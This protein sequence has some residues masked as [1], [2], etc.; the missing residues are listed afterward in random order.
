MQAKILAFWNSLPHWLTVLVVAF[1]GGEAGYFQTQGAATLVQALTSWPTL[2]HMLAGAL[3][4]GLLALA[5]QAKESF[6]VPTVARA[7]TR[8][9]QAQA[10][11]AAQQRAAA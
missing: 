11:Q 3:S 7:E 4:A 10:K 2:E 8:L 9:L 1:V 5:L 6:V